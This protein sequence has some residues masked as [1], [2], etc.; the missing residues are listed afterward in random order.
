MRRTT[1]WPQIFHSPPSVSTSSS[2]WYL[3]L[4]LTRV[5]MIDRQPTHP[6]RKSLIKPKL[7]PPIHCHQVSEPLVGK[8]YTRSM[9]ISL[10]S[11]VVAALPCATTYATLF[12]YFASDWCSSKRIA[13]V[14]YVIRPHLRGLIDQ[15]RPA[16]WGDQTNPSIAPCDWSILVS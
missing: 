2:I 1:N 10:Y 12:L 8:F 15:R 6:C 5:K 3:Y 11:A 9:S 14:R 16:G 13:V 7:A 4:T